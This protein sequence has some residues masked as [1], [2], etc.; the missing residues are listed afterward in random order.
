MPTK[1]IRLIRRGFEVVPDMSGKVTGKEAAW[2][3]FHVL[4]G[5]VFY[6]NEAPHFVTGLG[7]IEIAM[8]Q[9]VR[10]TVYAYEGVFQSAALGLSSS[11]GNYYEESDGAETYQIAIAR[12]TRAGLTQYH[13]GGVWINQSRYQDIHAA[14][15]DDDD[16]DYLEEQFTELVKEGKPG[17][18]TANGVVKFSVLDEDGDKK[19]TADVRLDA[20]DAYGLTKDST[21]P[22]A[23]TLRV[24]VKNSVELD[25]GK[26]QLVNDED[27]PGANEYYGTGG[28]GVKGYHGLV[29][30]KVAVNSSNT[31]DYLA[32]LFNDTGTMTGYD[33]VVYR[34]SLV[35]S[36]PN[37]KIRLYVTREDI[38]QKFSEGTYIDIANGEISVDLTEVSGYNAEAA[39]ILYH[40]ASGAFTW[41]TVTDD[42]SC[43]S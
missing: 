35:G 3:K 10:L 14:V 27:A 17:A 8:N 32:A 33:V 1:T 38:W 5:V 11:V 39:Q 2:G 24:Q 25:A 40:A 9:Y 13:D 30:E 21:T 19:I 28:T 26:I 37:Q 15:N 41:L 16:A 22:A 36:A 18:L 43:P 7:S 34:H 20:G 23:P 42:F 29:D 12:R 4:P 31:P 6:R